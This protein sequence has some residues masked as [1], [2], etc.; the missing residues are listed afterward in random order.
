MTGDTR[1][2]PAICPTCDRPLPSRD[3]RRLPHFPFCSRRCRLV[4]LG[5]WL[6]GDYRVVGPGL[7]PDEARDGPSRDL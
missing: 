2:G 4:D 7:A 3:L 5:R 6:D 1:P